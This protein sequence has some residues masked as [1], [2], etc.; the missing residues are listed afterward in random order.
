M[1]VVV[2]VVVESGRHTAGWPLPYRGCRE[3]STLV[4]STFR[5]LLAGGVGRLP[6]QRLHMHPRCSR[7]ST[8]R[9]GSG[10]RER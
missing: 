3:E 5:L 6:Q 7:V 2:V 8:V 1:A 10:E 4:E 9:R